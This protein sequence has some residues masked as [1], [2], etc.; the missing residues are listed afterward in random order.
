VRPAPSHAHESGARAPVSLRTRRSRFL[1][2][3]VGLIVL[4]YTIFALPGSPDFRGAGELAFSVA[5]DVLLVVFIARGSRVALA[6]ALVFSM[7]FVL[8][9]AFLSTAG[10]PVGT[11]AVVVVELA[12]IA[13]L[14]LLWREPIRH[15][16]DGAAERG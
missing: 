11:A 9:V 4:R 10:L 1:V 16:P 6:V 12:A 14:V 3:Y 8:S 13:A 5:I 2:V 15:E 7:L